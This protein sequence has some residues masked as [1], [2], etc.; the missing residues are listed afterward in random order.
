MIWKK[1]GRNGFDL[2]A[3]GNTVGYLPIP[4][5]HLTC[6]QHVGQQAV[7]IVIA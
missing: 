5:S 7:L 6:L 2:L 3:A 4:L 1:I